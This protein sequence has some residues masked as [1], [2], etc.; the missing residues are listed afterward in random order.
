MKRF[1]VQ[2]EG[3]SPILQ[4]RLSRDLMLELKAIPKSR[5]DAWEED[6]W[7]K[8]L[9]KN[10]KGEV[11]FPDLNV[12]AMLQ[13]AARNYKISPPKDVG[14][15]WT[16]YVKSSV[17]VEQ[18]CV[19]KSEKPPVAYGCMVNGNPSSAKKSSKVYKVRPRIDLPW[20]T[21]VVFLDTN[22]F[23]NKD[24]VADLMRTAG[25]FVGMSDW[26]PQ[27]GRFVVKRVIEH[28]IS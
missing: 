18:A 14:K 17:V 12:H 26:R 21:T 5:L 25:L 10:E 3:A 22:D 1:E 19:I 6:N 27:F 20:S 13:S 24:I 2:I 16:N 9:Y 11:V 23:L 4:N 7:E 15:T 8:K 28:K